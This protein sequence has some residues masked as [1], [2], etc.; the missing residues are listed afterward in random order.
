MVIPHDPHIPPSSVFFFRVI[1]RSLM[2]NVAT[3]SRLVPVAFQ[4]GKEWK[5]VNWIDSKVSSTMIYLYEK[6]NKCA[7]DF[8]FIPCLDNLTTPSIIND[9][10]LLPGNVRGCRNSQDIR[11]SSS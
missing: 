6:R 8:Q 7:S 5:I 2:R 4:V 9:E 1:G 11:L 10:I 3:S